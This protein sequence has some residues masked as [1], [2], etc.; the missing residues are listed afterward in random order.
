M[1]YAS[2]RLDFGRAGANFC[3]RPNGKLRLASAWVRDLFRRDSEPEDRC[4]GGRS[5]SVAR[6]A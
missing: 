2:Q 4:A 6:G 5:L 1:R 3:W